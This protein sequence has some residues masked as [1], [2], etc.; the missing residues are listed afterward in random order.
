MLSPLLWLLVLNKVL[1]ALEKEGVRT[2][3]YADD[4]VLMSSGKFLDVIG[5][6]STS[7]LKTIQKWARTKGLNVNPNKMET[8]LFSRKYKIPDFELPEVNGT[9]LALKTRTEEGVGATVFC[10]DLNLNLS[11]RLPDQSSIFQAEI[12]AIYKA[13]KTALNS[14]KAVKTINIFVDSQAA[15]KAFNSNQIKSKTTMDCF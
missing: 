2:V 10:K 1:I 8:V 14:Q 6:L 4:V 13:A 15:L 5:D 12:I 3:A 11:Y 9:R 7:A